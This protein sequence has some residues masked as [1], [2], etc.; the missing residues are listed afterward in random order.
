MST[1][2]SHEP[3]RSSPA[4]WWTVVVAG[5]VLG[6]LA[7]SCGS[8]PT[9]PAVSID[10][11]RAQQLMLTGVN[12]TGITAPTEVWVQVAQRGCINGAWDWTVAKEV[13]DAAT[14][15]VGKPLPAGLV[16][17]LTVMA[18]RDLVPATA[19]EQGPPS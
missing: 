8:Q 7:A 12:M 15:I 6:M 5:V 1:C 19:I 18:C 13:G 3:A 2:Q 11:E 10:A 16:W 9:S 17:V 14:D 4:T